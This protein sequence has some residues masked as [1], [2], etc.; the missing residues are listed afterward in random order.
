MATKKSAS[1]NDK[2]VRLSVSLPPALHDAVARIAKTKKVSNAWVVR[3][4]LE[5]YVRE[6]RPTLE[7]RT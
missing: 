3:D 7:R 2:K 6:Q 1:F 4:A 5:A